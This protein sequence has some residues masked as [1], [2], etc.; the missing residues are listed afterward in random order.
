MFVPIDSTAVSIAILAACLILVL[1]GRGRAQ[2][3]KVILGGLAVAGLMVAVA[4][5]AE[6]LR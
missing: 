1:A 6:G 2:R 5:L 4:L 3:T